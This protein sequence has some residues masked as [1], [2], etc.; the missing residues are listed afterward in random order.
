MRRHELDLMSLT[1][2]L[3]FTAIGLAGLLS[4]HIDARW[5]LPA[6]LGVL[7]LVGLAATARAARRGRAQDTTHDELLTQDDTAPLA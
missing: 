3:T 2:G 4:T 6:V 1:F 7:G 5:I